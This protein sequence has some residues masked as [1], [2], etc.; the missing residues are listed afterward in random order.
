V[1]ARGRCSPGRRAAP[2]D[3]ERVV[4]RLGHALREHDHLG[5]VD[6]R[7]EYGE[8]VA[9]EASHSVVAAHRAAQPGRDRRDQL[10]PDVVAKGVVD[11][12]EVVEI[13]DHDGDR[14]RRPAGRGEGAL[15]AQREHRAVGQ[16]GQRVV[17]RL[18]LSLDGES[19]GLV[20]R[21]DRQQQQR[22]QPD[23]E[24]DRPP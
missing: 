4:E 20:H 3:G 13:D 16:P 10:V 9:A 5:G 11:L 14:R 24:R 15:H 17:Q 22:D 12:L 1:R 8:L 2:L 6:T 23:R 19:G 7:R 21:D 18:P